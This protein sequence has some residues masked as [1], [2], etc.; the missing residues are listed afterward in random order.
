MTLIA[1]LCVDNVWWYKFIWK[2]KIHTKFKISM[3]VILNNR[4]PT[5]DILQNGTFVGL[6][7]CSLCQK[8]EETNAHIIITY[9]Y[10]K[11]LWKELEKMIGYQN[12]WVRDDIEEALRIQCANKYIKKIIAIPLNISWAVWL[13]KNLN[14]FEDKEKLPLKCDLHVPNILN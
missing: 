5:W 4:D 3:W 11:E 2:L 12:V 9:P 10:T 8:V 1:L 6:N 7:Q 13:D 14:L